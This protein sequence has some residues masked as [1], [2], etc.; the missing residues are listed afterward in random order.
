MD[1]ELRQLL[2][3]PGRAQVLVVEL[4]SLDEHEQEHPRANVVGLHRRLVG[5][6]LRGGV[7]PR[8][9][10]LVEVG[11]AEK[12]VLRVVVVGAREGSHDAAGVETGDVAGTDERHD[13]LRLV[14]PAEVEVDGHPCVLPILEFLRFRARVIAR[15]RERCAP[16]DR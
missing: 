8:Q 16:P 7:P 5:R 9:V 1:R 12:R 13:C 3:A 10:D 11:V 6:E 14:R 2:L 15:N 4:R